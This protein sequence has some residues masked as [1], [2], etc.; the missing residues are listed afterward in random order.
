M[1]V[2]RHEVSET[3]SVLGPAPYGKP[4]KMAALIFK[5]AK[6]YHFDDAT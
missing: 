2:I 5:N 4:S 1:Y 6:F 3:S